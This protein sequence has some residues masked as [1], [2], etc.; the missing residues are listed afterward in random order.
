M[1]LNE[2]ID[3]RCCQ[4]LSVLFVGRLLFSL[5]IYCCCC[6]WLNHRPTKHLKS[7]EIHSKDDFSMTKNQLVIIVL[8]PSAESALFQSL[9]VPPSSLLLFSLLSNVYH[10]FF[11]LCSFHTQ[12]EK[13]PKLLFAVLFMQIW[14]HHHSIVLGHFF[15]LCALQIVGNS[16]TNFSVVFMSRSVYMERWNVNTAEER[17][18]EFC[19]RAPVAVVLC[20]TLE[21]FI[22]SL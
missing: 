17:K 10:I 5:V 20:E 8:V 3:C 13:S 15:S 4:K 7:I 6:C 21:C 22:K 19:S 18:V 9:H 11:V 2:T 12:W 14:L 16:T 1:N